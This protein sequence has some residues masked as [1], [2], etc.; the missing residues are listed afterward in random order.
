MCRRTDLANT[1]VD[2][3]LSS[4]DAAETYCLRAFGEPEK[5]SC[6]YDPAVMTGWAADKLCQPTFT[7]PYFLK[8]SSASKVFAA[9]QQLRESCEAIKSRVRRRLEQSCQHQT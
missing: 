8:D 2:A 5:S 9:V 7:L 4:R 1:Q 6:Y 3:S